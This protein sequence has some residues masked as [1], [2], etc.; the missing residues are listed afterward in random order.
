MPRDPREEPDQPE[1]DDPE[2]ESELLESESRLRDEPESFDSPRT[3]PLTRESCACAGATESTT[4]AT[5]IPLPM[6]PSLV[7]AR[8]R[9]RQST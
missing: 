3:A 4:S 8:A 9:I 5:K 1:P 7:R 2:S 6:A